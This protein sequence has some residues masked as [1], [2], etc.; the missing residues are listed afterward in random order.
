MVPYMLVT[1]NA[2]L[3]YSGLSESCVRN[4]S[5]CL[6]EGHGAQ[7]PAGTRYLVGRG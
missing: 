5:N 2:E 3:T 6:D 7:I 4:A 1:A